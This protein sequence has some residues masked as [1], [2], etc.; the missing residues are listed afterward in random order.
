VDL[1][2]PAPRPHR[3]QRGEQAVIRKAEVEHHEGLARGNSGVDD[4]RQLRDGVLV[5]ARDRQAHP[6][7]DSGIILRPRPPLP[8]AGQ[9]RP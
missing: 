2:H 4:G 3:D 7:V 1:E 6:V 9:Q 8:Q 5:L